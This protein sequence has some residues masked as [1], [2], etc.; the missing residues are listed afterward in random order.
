MFRFSYEHENKK[1]PKEKEI[2]FFDK[3]IINICTFFFYAILIG[4]LPL[5]T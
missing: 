1:V 3:S 4:S 2:N 5:D